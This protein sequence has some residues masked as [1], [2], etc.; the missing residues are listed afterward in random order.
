MLTGLSNKIIVRNL[1]LFVLVV[2][3]SCS[4]TRRLAED[5]YLL[6]KVKT[7]VDSKTIDAE[8]L[9]TYEKQTPNKTILGVKFHLF[10]YNLASP[11]KEKGISGWL[12]KIGEEP[13]IW[14]PLLTERTTE[15]F[16]TYLKTRGY[17]DSYVEDTVIL[18]NQKAKV[19]R[20][21]EL[22]KPYIIRSISYRFEDQKISGL[23]LNDTANRLIKTGDRF[24]M[25]KL[26]QERQRL[27]E[28]L[29]N[30]GYFRFS[31]EY[32][33]FDATE[34]PGSKQVDLKILIRENITGIP[35]PETKVRH[36][37]QYKINSVYIY[38]DFSL[39][40]DI[41]D[42]N[43][44]QVDTINRDG[45]HIIYSGKLRIRP[46]IL[47]WPNLCDPGD[48]Y[49]LNNLKKTYSNYSSLGLFRVINIHFKELGR[50]FSDSSNYRYIDS[51]IELSPRK[52]Q[53]YDAEIVGTNSSGDFGARTNFRYYNYNLLRGAENLEVRVTGAIEQMKRRTSYSYL[54]PMLEAGIEATLSVPKILVPFKARQFTMRYN[55]KTLFNVSYNYQNRPDYIRTIA[56]T[57][58]S[59][60]LKGNQFTSHQ[61]FP[62]EFN[63]VLLPEGIRDS[64]LNAEIM[65]TALANSFIDHT[66]LDARYTFEYNNQIV[67]RRGDFIF[68]RTNLESAGSLIHYIAKRTSNE[69]DTN[70]LK[71][72]Y[73]RYLRFDADFRF[74]KQ[75]TEGNRI[76]YRIFIGAGYPLGDQHTLPFEKM[77]FGGGPNGVRAWNSYELGPGSVATNSV[78]YASNL[79]DVKLE[80]NLEYRFQLFWVMEGALFVDAGNIW[81]IYNIENRPNSSFDWGRFYK[82]IAIGT[83]IGFRF[84][85][86]FLM[87]R[88]DFGIKMRDPVITSGSRW[89]DLNPNVHYKFLPI[90][91]K[92]GQKA[93]LSFQFGI[94]Y[95]F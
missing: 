77:Y 33:F 39:F 64:S 53:S 90:K 12:R 72:P 79:G 4:P 74:N 8:D 38:P 75:I 44:M 67:G 21:V 66:I 69:N 70:F 62:V 16:K 48:L 19:Y 81:T 68:L 31:K 78:N 57:S 13:V 11:E 29:K 15:Q 58:M 92:E 3:W 50:D 27:E 82:E 49:R 1:V 56:S 91:L 28:L 17:Y 23:I 54:K 89:I 26:Q 7:K 30:N 73:F 61:L 42:E 94:G 51:Y 95:P 5:E 93:R 71:V 32:I 85:F 24:D 55:P 65:K 18:K 52:P 46:E 84:D 88:T 14:N 36:H 10:L 6:D 80:G 60:K 22:N 2:G 47:L 37:E 35:D 83:G 9:K 40:S 59:Y 76:V 25:E 43:S 34:I 41:S 87:L 86:S 45:T 20:S 63:Y